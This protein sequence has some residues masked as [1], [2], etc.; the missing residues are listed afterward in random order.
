MALLGATSL[1]GDATR[2]SFR[3]PG[4]PTFKEAVATFG[5]A[6]PLSAHRLLHYQPIGMPC[7]IIL[8]QEN[9]AD[10]PVRLPHSSRTTARLEQNPAQSSSSGRAMETGGHGNPFDSPG[11]KSPLGRFGRLPE[12]PGF[13]CCAHQVF[14]NSKIVQ[15]TPRKGAA[16]RG[17]SAA[18]Y[19]RTWNGHRQF[20]NDRSSQCQ[21]FLNDAFTTSPYIGDTCYGAI[22]CAVVPNE[23]E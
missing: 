18:S 3:T 13:L 6:L 23:L 21:A 2:L 11:P 14:G 8:S 22:P 12:R 17:N 1:I 7:C 19:F 4:L 5:L 20:W 10:I 9:P 16:T 15:W